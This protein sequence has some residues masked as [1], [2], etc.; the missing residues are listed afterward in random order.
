VQDKLQRKRIEALN[1]LSS[2]IF[3]LKDQ[4]HDQEGLGGKLS[5]DDKKTLMAAVK[6]G[7]EWVEENGGDASL[8]DLEEKLAGELYLV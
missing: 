8:E 4:I 7:A 2:F 6:E 1:S 5:S 3:G